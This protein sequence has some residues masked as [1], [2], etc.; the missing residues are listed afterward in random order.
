MS[1]QARPTPRATARLAC[2]IYLEPPRPGMDARCPK[3]GSVASVDDAMERVRC[4][5]CG[6]EDT[7]DGYLETM[8]E[9]AVNMAADYIPDRPGM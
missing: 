8:K 7:Y 6:Y 3:C 1:C 5:H 4:P 2:V 9:E